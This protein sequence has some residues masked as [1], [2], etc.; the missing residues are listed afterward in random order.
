MK[1]WLILALLFAAVPASAADIYVAQSSAGGNTGAD[2][3]DARAVSSLASG[4][5]TAGNTIHLCG[6]IT[7]AITAQGSGSSGSVITVKFESGASMQMPAIPS[8]GGIVLNTRSYILIDGGGGS[9][10]WVSYADVTC[11]QGAILSTANGTGQAN[12]V[13]SIAIY[14]PNSANIEVK[15]LLIGPLYT[16]TSTSDLVLSP[17]GALCAYFSGGSHWKIHNNTL[18]DASWCIS[19]GSATGDVQVYNDEI[20]NIDHGLGMGGPNNA[21]VIHD[22]HIHDFANWDTTNNSFHHD[23]IHIWGTT[24][25]ANTNAQ[26]Y[27]NLIDGDPGANWTADIYN[28]GLDTGFLMYNNVALVSAA[29]RKSCC[30]IMDF[31]GNGYTGDHNSAYNNTVIGVYVAGTGSCFGIET[32][33]N[34][35]FEN[36]TLYGCQGMIGWDAGSSII[37][38]DY[39]AYEDVGTDHGIGAAANTFGYPSPAPQSASFTTWK[40]N[41]SCDA[42][43]QFGTTSQFAQ[44]S[45]GTFRSGSFLS[46]NGTNLSSLSITPLDSDTQGTSRP[47]G[48]TAWDIGAFSGASAPSAPSNLQIIILGEKGDTHGTPSI[49]QLGR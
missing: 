32:N 29:G 12:Q 10:G 47:G 11:S 15:G 7:S 14:A 31:W 46:G 22:N 2:C 41:C 8:T 37:T 19:G 33:T 18:H 16:H 34:V 3:A 23:G 13:A 35:T 5:W 39:N 43:S 49:A 42:H 24:G 45:N 27:N 4:D 9:C 6:T 48:S 40:T 21:I 17:P 20:Y 36:N 38:V 44:N 28:E 25:S 1:I 30:G 26:E